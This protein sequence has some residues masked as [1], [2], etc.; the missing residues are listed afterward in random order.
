MPTKIEKWEPD[1][2]FCF[3]RLKKTDKKYKTMVF[4]HCIK[5]STR[6]QSQREEKQ[7]RQKD[8]CPYVQLK[9]GKNSQPPGKYL[10][11]LFFHFSEYVKASTYSAN[12]FRVPSMLQL[13]AFRTSNGDKQETSKQ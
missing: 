1:L 11:S 6:Q 12:T 13:E 8:T 5:G 7:M 9:S 2:L 3:K 10:Q 4:K